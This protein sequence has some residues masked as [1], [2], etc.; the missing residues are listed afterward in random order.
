[1]WFPKVAPK[2]AFAS[3]LGVS[4]KLTTKDKLASWACSGDPLCKFC[5]NQ[6]EFFY[7][8]FFLMTKS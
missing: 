1:M 8:P 7:M 6:M 4:N 2:H 3:W 5:R